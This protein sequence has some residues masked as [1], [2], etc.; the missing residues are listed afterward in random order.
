MLIRLRQN[1]TDWHKARRGPARTFA[2][3]AMTAFSGFAWRTMRAPAALKAADR[4][5]IDPLLQFIG[6]SGDKYP[7]DDNYYSSG[8]NC[9]GACG[10]ALACDDGS[11][12][13]GLRVGEAIGRGGGADV[14]GRRFCSEAL[15]IRRVICS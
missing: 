2:A 10:C 11:F 3:M 12:G 9:T 6:V 14:L 13:T 15:A 8:C 5:D 7:A 1:S 4:D